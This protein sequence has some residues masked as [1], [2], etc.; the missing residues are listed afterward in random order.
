MSKQFIRLLLSVRIAQA[1]KILRKTAPPL[2][3]EETISH[4][5]NIVYYPAYPSQV[6]DDRS[7]FMPNLALGAARLSGCPGTR[8]KLCDYSYDECNGS[9]RS[10]MVRTRSSRSD[11]HTVMPENWTFKNISRRVLWKATREFCVRKA[12]DFFHRQPLLQ[13]SSYV[14]SLSRL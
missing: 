9:E 2:I 14:S 6:L 11:L 1:N 13:C 10:G 8:R 5:R 3:E 7:D 4:Y 12:E